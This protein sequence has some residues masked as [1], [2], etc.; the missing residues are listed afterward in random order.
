M[1][2]QL[3][4]DGHAGIADQANDIRLAGEQ[5]HDLIF[6]KSDFTKSITDFGRGAQAADANGGARLDAREWTQGTTIRFRT[7]P[8]GGI[9]RWHCVAR[10]D[11]GLHE[12][13]Q[14]EIVFCF[15]DL[16]CAWS[17]K[18]RS[19]DSSLAPLP[20]TFP[21]RCLMKVKVCGRLR[22]YPLERR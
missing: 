10:G 8:D 20:R 3:F 13:W 1:P 7:G 14:S 5:T 17:M 18:K 16:S 11:E 2:S 19:L 9:H 21:M 6:A 4:A 15:V 22:G 12:I